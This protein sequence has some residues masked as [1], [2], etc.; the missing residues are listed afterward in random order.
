M[1]FDHKRFFEGY[2]RE[3]GPIPD[4]KQYIVQGLEGLLTRFETYYGWWDDL[5]QIANALAQVGRE[6]AYSYQPVAEAYYLGDPSKPGYYAGNTATVRRVQEN[7]RYY[8]FFGRGHIQLTWEEGYRKMNSYLRKYF[9]EVVAAVEKRTGKPFDLV[10]HPELATDFDVSFCVFT[11]GMHLGI[12]RPGHTLDRY[13]TPT[14]VDHYAARDIVNG[15]KG[16][17]DKSSGQLIGRIIEGHAK[18]WTR[19]LQAALISVEE[20]AADDVSALVDRIGMAEGVGLTEHTE[21]GGSWEDSPG[22]GPDAELLA[23]GGP[24][25]DPDPAGGDQGPKQVA[26]NITNVNQGQQLPDGAQPENKTLTAPAPGNMLSRAWKWILG[27]GI[28]PTTGFGVL[29]TFKQIMADGQVNWREVLQGSKEVL[30]FLLPWLFWI[31]LAFIVFWGLKELLKQISFIV[32]QYTTARLDMNN[33][34]VL[35]AAEPVATPGFVSR[36]ISN[37]RTAPEPGGIN[38]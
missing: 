2:R 27:L 32:T 17:K 3:F 1:R 35:P 26:E 37:F 20:P 19:I 23:A 8:P 15:D 6:S 18:K 7:F 9:P 38:L 33:V 25:G 5:D 4:G 34:R 10:K 30:I 16:Y 36:A 13:I 31:A 21:A 11:V 14:H 29:E 28:I 12:F 22:P 24:L